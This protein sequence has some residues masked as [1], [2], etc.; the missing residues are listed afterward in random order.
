MYGI[1]GEG[2]PKRN[3]NEF[4]HFSERRVLSLQTLPR[5]PAKKADP[6]V[7]LKI[8]AMPQC[9]LSS[10]GY[11]GAQLDKARV[12]GGTDASD[13][14]ERTKIAGEILMRVGEVRVVKQIENVNAQLDF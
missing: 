4:D 12:G 8:G 10:E 13:N 6:K 2:L 1:F 14:A 5:A 7:G 11:P 3:S 9:L